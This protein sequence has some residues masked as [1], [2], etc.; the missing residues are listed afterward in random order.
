MGV[1]AVLAT[2]VGTASYAYTASDSVPTTYAGDGANTISG[3]TVGSLAYTLNGPN[4]SRVDA[5]TFTLTP[6]APLATKVS[7]RLAAGGSWYTCTVAAGNS[8]T[9]PTTS[10]QAT[11]VGATQLT[12]VAV[13]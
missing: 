4:P 9:C 6:A 3:Y 7:A 2:L 5:V 10:P 11:A 13:Q 8:V 12:V 1:A